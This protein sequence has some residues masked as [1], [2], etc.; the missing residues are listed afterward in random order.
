MGAPE[1]LEFL[2]GSKSNV[3]LSSFYPVDPTQLPKELAGVQW[4][5]K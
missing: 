5:T 2:R 4:P 1:E 3:D